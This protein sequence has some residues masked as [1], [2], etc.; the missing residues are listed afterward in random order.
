MIYAVNYIALF[1]CFS[2]RWEGKRGR[3]S[4]GAIPFEGDGARE[5]MGKGTFDIS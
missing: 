4:E 5:E 2:V 3:G 1:L